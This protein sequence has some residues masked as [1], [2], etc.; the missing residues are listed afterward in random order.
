M[1]KTLNLCEIKKDF[2]S[3][4]RED[5]IEILL[6]EYQHCIKLLMDGDKTGARNLACG[7]LDSPYLNEKLESV[8]DIHDSSIHILQVYNELNSFASSN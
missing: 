5:E 3:N 8:K 6:N 4:L 7:L 1:F 2:T